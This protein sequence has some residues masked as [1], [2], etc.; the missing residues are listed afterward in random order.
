MIIPIEKRALDILKTY[1][2]NND[3]ILQ[4]LKEYKRTRH[5]ILTSS[6]AK[7]I[8]KFHKTEAISIGKTVQVHKACRAFLRDQFKADDLPEKIYVKKILSRTDDLLHIWGCL[9]EDNGKYESFFIAKEC[10]KKIRQVPEIDFSKYKRQPLPHQL[11]AIKKLMENEKFL[12]ADDQ[13]LAKTS[14]AILAAL[15]LGFE[16]ILVVCPATLKLNWKYE[17]SLYDNPKDIHVVTSGDFT[18][19]KW[20]I[21]NYDILKNFH[22]TPTRGMDISDL[23]PS[24]IDYYKYDLVISDECQFLKNSKSDRAK[25]FGSFALNIPNRWFLSGTPITNHPIDLFPILYLCD[26]PVATNWM[27]YVTRYC[28]AKRFNRKGTK[29]KYWVTSGASNINELKEYVADIMLRRLKSDSIDLPQKTVKP[30]F[31]PLE[32]S[33]TYNAYMKEYKDWALNTNNSLEKPNIAEHLSKLIKIRQLLS[34]DKVQHTIEL[35]EDL[36]DNGRKV[37]IF[38][39]FTNAIHAIHDHFGNKSVLI[40]GS[41][42]SEKRQG[43]VNKFQ[44]DDKVKVFCGN[45]IAAGVGITLTEGTVVIFNDLD[46][47]PANH[48]QGSDRI[49]RIGQDKPVHIIYPLFDDTLD[50]IMYESLQKKIEIISQ[51]MG[52]EIEPIKDISIGR[53]VVNSL[54]GIVN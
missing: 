10:L 39:C 5:F 7:Y 44:S 21:I 50:V 34:Q 22:Y 4:L 31:L 2:G 9:N 27:H 33:T 6:Q 15:E 8:V 24:T 45:I 54:L 13:G 35:A 19:K 1:T 49:F 36:I 52:D 17:I 20:T 32:Y 3:H 30:V 37:V 38:S 26:S 18:C 23:P 46:W 43:I 28:D 11:P 47:T 53:E 40:D 12:L 41:T 16:R 25:I 42:Q 51:I 14:T 48:A 29:Q